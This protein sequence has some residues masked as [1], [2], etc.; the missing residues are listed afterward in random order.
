MTE[1]DDKGFDLQSSFSLEN[2]GLFQNP[3]RP[4]DLLRLK[5]IVV[6]KF[7]FTCFFNIFF[8]PMNRDEM[9][10]GLGINFNL[11][12]GCANFVADLLLVLSDLK[13]GPIVPV[14]E[15][16]IE[17]CVPVVSSYLDF[18]VE[19][20]FEVMDMLLKKY[21]KFLDSGIN[22]SPLSSVKLFEDDRGFLLEGNSPLV[23]DKLFLY[24]QIGFL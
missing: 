17:V 11:N 1:G 7:E 10:L 15:L 3:V 14:P 2:E 8:F 9:D 5:V 19:S 18:E 16:V 21:L 20:N 6:L 23:N 12:N 22:G 24:R 13:S 4:V